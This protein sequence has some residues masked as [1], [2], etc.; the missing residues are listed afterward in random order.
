MTFKK[1][2]IAGA[3][4]YLGR[5]IL[6]HLLTIPTVSRVT[7]LT[8]S[9]LAD[10]PSS[11]ILT[12]ISIPSYRAVAALTLALQGHELLISALSRLSAD[13]TDE[14][15]IAAAI[16]AGVRRYMPSEYTVD[17]MHPHAIAVSGSTVIA[18]KIASAQRVQHSAE[19]GQIEYTTLVTG[20]SQL[21]D[22]S[23]P[24]VAMPQ[25]LLG[26]STPENT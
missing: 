7:V 5:K 25:K 19:K 18:G 1:I 23:I 10:F 8:H 17:C 6:D 14:F 21:L 15:L 13:E 16:A 3:S 4:G 24:L 9:P 2:A 11:P 12:F 20:E 26:Y 22:M